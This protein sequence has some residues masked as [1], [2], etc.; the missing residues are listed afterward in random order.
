LSTLF[1]VRHGETVWHAENRYA[2]VSDVELTDLGRRQ[3]GQLGAWAVRQGI[4]A[5]WT[6]TL[7]RARQTAAPAARLLGISPVEATDLREL[8]FGDAEGRVLAEL[9]PAVV[10]AFRS[11]PAAHP[12]PGGEDPAAAARRGVACLY[13]I[14]ERHPDGRVLVVT[15][16][17]LL[18][19]VLCELLGIRLGAYRRVFPQVRNCA[20][21]ELRLA[22]GRTALIDYNVPVG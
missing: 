13:R 9:D 14:A 4:D 3:A 7:S 6:S 10:A 22:S 2:G 16:N 15:H 1:L 17:T 20:T 21:T 12:L 19:L 11:D 8:D 18:R 5:V